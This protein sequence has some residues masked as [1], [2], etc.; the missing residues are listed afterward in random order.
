MP[1]KHFYFSVGA[2][3]G[4]GVCAWL[5]NKRHS[6][7]KSSR[8]FGWL[9][10]KYPQWFLFFPIII[11]IVALWGLIPDMIHLSGWL[12]KEVTRGSWFNVFFL[13]SFFEHVENVYPVIDR[14]LNFLGHLFIVGVSL[15]VMVYYVKQVVKAQKAHVSAKLKRKKKC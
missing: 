12:P 8:F 7:R 10:Q 5:A 14:W 9:Y 3:V 11:F 4:S 15:G 2:V 1:E 13:H 6:L